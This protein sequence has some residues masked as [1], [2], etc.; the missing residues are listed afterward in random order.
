MNRPSLLRLAG[1][2]LLAASFFVFAYGLASVFYGHIAVTCI[3]A[4]IFGKAAMPVDTH[5]FRVSERL[6]LTTNSKT[7]L[8]TER[9]LMRHI[10][11]DQVPKAHHWLI[12]HGRYICKA[13]KPECK[14]CYLT[15]ICRYYQRQASAAKAKDAT[16][17]A[18]KSKSAENVD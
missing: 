6:G 7:P 13:R 18:K 11:A 5:V 17:T 9:A 12:L 2:L 14:D 3:L 10:P 16:S 4:V 15:D 8:A 1:T